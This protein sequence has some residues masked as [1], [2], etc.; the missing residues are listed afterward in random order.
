LADKDRRSGRTGPVGKSSAPR[1]LVRQTTSDELFELHQRTGDPL[2][3]EELV[4]R[5][6]PLA[7]NLARRYHSKG[8]SLDDLRQVANVGLLKAIAKFDPERGFA[9][10]SYATPT[11]LG[12]LK[13]YFRDSGW[14]L[15]VPR[16]VKER[17][18]ELASVSEQLSSRLGRSP[19][20][21]ELA[22]ELELSEEQTLDALEAY[23]ARHVSPLEERTDDDSQPRRSRADSLG[24][25]DAG[26]ERSEYMTMITKGIEGLRESERM[27]LFLRFAQDL[28]QS[29]IASRVGVSQMQ[30]SRLLR[31]AIEK[32]RAASGEEDPE[33]ALG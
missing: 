21:G 12:E 1:D 30:V 17:A 18:L 11:I 9:F 27:I 4:R 22:Q 3:R 33:E 14:A 16:G 26:L 5:Y 32:L 19:S 31:G 6:E 8:E 29:E 25:E 7:R 23:H 24:A 2:V 10:T 20:I 15:H 28:T 13:R